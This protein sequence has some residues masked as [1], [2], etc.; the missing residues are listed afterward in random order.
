MPGESRSIRIETA[1]DKLPDAA[2]TLVV[3]AY[4]AAPRE[5]RIDIPRD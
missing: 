2:Y 1:L 3:R 5:F 4:N